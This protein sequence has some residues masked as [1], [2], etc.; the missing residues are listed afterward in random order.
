[1]TGI[2]CIEDEIED[3]QSE[4]YS[5]DRY[6]LYFD[7]GEDLN[8]LDDYKL[9]LENRLMFLNEVLSGIQSGYYM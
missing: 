3:I 7:F 1:M 8:S 2:K 6:N 4:L 5:I 9:S